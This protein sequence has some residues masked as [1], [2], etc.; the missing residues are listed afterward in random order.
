MED[1]LKNLKKRSQMREAVQAIVKNS[2]YQMIETS[3]FEPYDTFSKCSGRIK[4]E[5]TVKVI[6]NLGGIEILRPDITFNII[7]ALSKVYQAPKQL[8]LCYDSTVFEND[9]I[10]GIKE[11]RQIGA[12]YLGNPS[13]D[14]DLEIIKLS[15]QVLKLTKN[16]VLVIGHNKY[17][18]GLLKEI[19][20]SD[21]IKVEIKEIIYKK[22]ALLLEDILKNLFIDSEVKSKLFMLLEV[23][24]FDLK[25]YA[26][27]FMNVEMKIALSEIGY[28]LDNLDSEVEFD[29]SLLSK[30]DYY[31]GVIFKG[32]K[33][34]LN[35]PIIRGGRYDQLSSLF[36]RAIPA[37]GFSVEFD[38]LMRGVKN[39]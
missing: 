20:C 2:G 31:N 29:L 32:Y 15:M 39:D 18:E 16:S 35:M 28:L 14:A 26:R 3:Y 11:K 19:D 10:Q 4:K 7:Q 17:L 8:K 12:E 24:N 34:G 37:V 25:D 30:F 33:K 27:G 36:N 23:D 6:N 38:V 1:Y 21:D 5:R 13:I 9:L 22:Q